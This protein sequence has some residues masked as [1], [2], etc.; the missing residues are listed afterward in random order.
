MRSL[1]SNIKK[2][3][4]SLCVAAALLLMTLSACGNGSM[5]ISHL[6]NTRCESKLASTMGYSRAEQFDGESN[7]LTREQSDD[8]GDGAAELEK[9]KKPEEE[10]DASTQIQ[11]DGGGGGAPDLTE[12]HPVLQ[13]PAYPNG[14]EI[15]SLAAVLQYNGFDATLDELNETYLPRQDFSFSKR[16]A[17]GPDPEKYYVGDPASKQGWYCF[18][19]PLADAADAYLSDQGSGLRA[20]ILTGAGMDELK[21]WL[22]KGVPIIVWFTVNYGTPVYSSGF[23]WILE[24]GEQYIPYSNLHCLVLTAIEEGACRL[25]DSL[26]GITEVGVEHFEKIYTQMGRRALVVI[27]AEEV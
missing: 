9:L 2:R 4:V 21:A 13:N 6:Q 1:S 17:F 22:E 26:A 19:Q 23:R 10:S 7:A 3:S 20:C 25:A 27:P 11:P 18:E 12:L 16:G 15:A 24:T 14:C 8:G 5:E